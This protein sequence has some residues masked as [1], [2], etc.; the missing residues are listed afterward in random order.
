MRPEE[1]VLQQSDADMT[2]QVALGY[3]QS[4]QAEFMQVQQR[5]SSIQDQLSLHSSTMKTPWLMRQ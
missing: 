1:L 4:L 3:L 5:V 2:V